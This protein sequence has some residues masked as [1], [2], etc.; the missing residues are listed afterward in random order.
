MIAWL[1]LTA[2]AD[3]NPWSDVLEEGPLVPEE[4][5]PEPEPV[6]EPE[7]P[8]T[9]EPR[10]LA[11][12]ENEP[13]PA[14]PLETIRIEPTGPGAGLTLVTASV[15]GG[16]GAT[17]AF[18]ARSRV[19][20]DDV[21][22]S[23]AIPFATW[24]AAEGRDA[25]LG[26]LNATLFV[27]NGDIAWGA[28][29]QVPLGQTTTWVNEAEELWTSGGLDVIAIWQ[30][31]GTVTLLARGAA[32]LHFTPGY[33]PVPATYFKVSGTFAADL[34]VNDELGLTGEAS[35]G[36]WDVSPFD[37]GG[38]VRYDPIDDL[39]IRGGLVFPLASWVGLQ[40]APVP[41]GLREATLRVDVTAGF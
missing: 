29:L 8:P 21:S 20:F 9:E 6:E 26:N 41:A 5:A 7:P 27:R 4:P 12:L 19:S 33:E 30:R 35:L 2:A 37:V 34:A 13:T 23:L 18:T 10:P 16:D 22:F 15:V 11:D 3:D 1:A 32:G 36:W 28:A 17:T 40:P 25:G 31:P 24:R 14:I 38:L 39:R